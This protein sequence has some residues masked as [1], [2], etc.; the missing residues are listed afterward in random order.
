MGN[1]CQNG[2]SVLGSSFKKSDLEDSGEFKNREK[3][4]IFQSLQIEQEREEKIPKRKIRSEP[5]RIMTKKVKT[6]NNLETDE[7]EEIENNDSFLQQEQPSF[8]KS[9][10]IQDITEQKPEKIEQEKEEKKIEEKFL[11]MEK[12]ENKKIISK[13]SYLVNRLQQANW[14]TLGKDLGS[15]GDYLKKS[16]VP[17]D[18]L[19]YIQHQNYYYVGEM[20]NKEQFHGFG[21][22][23]FMNRDYYKGNFRNGNYC[24]K[25]LRVKRNGHIQIGFFLGGK[26]HGY[27]RVVD[28][29]GNYE[30][31]NFKDGKEEGMSLRYDQNGKFLNR[32][33]YMA[34]STL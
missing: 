7:N 18:Q 15:L 11:M 30:E 20:N 17:E 19:R 27:V 9:E 3:D 8:Q 14:K 12:I 16:P 1:Y 23:Y 33:M 13:L 25:G 6:W 26:P 5:E 32:L 24:G 29:I 21:N 10:T 4:F 34:G 2:E 31:V 28:N 22:I